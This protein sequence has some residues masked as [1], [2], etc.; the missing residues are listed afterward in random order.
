MPCLVAYIVILSK[1]L[2]QHVVAVKLRGFQ[3][4]KENLSLN[5]QTT[6]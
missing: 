5:R 6:F 4:F 2:P 3:V 1:M